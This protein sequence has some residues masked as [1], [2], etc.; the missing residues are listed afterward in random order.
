M[1]LLSCARA[2]MLYQRLLHQAACSLASSSGIVLIYMLYLQAVLVSCTIHA[3]L[4]TYYLTT[5][6]STTQ[7][8]TM[9]YILPLLNCILHQRN[10]FSLQISQA[11]P[12]NIL[13]NISSNC[14]FH[15]CYLPF[16]EKSFYFVVYVNYLYINRL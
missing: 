6:T 8:C 2:R 10:A 16:I 13:S 12:T 5:T 14:V 4:F 1:V 15:R 7:L 11:L 3:P 9:Q